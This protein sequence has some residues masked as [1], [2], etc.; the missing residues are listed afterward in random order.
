MS[1]SIQLFKYLRPG[2]VEGR[3]QKKYAIKTVIKHADS[4][5]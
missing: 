2:Y 1:D 3:K 5:K 4:W